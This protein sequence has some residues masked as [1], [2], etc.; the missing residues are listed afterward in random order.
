MAEADYSA[1]ERKDAVGVNA[2][3]PRWSNPLSLS[4]Y[5]IVTFH[6]VWLTY[7]ALSL[8]L[9]KAW[10]YLKN[11]PW[12]MAALYDYGC[13]AVFSFI[14]LW[15]RDGPPMFGI[16]GKYYA[17]IFPFAGNCVLLAYAAF[18]FQT[19]GNSV[20]ALLPKT[21]QSASPQKF[22]AT[23]I[24]GIIFAICTLVQLQA[25]IRA[26]REQSLLA[27]LKEIIAEPWAVLTVLDAYEGNLFGL[28]F[29]LVREG[30]TSVWTTLIWTLFFLTM[31]SF[32]I[33]LYALLVVREALVRD[34][35]FVEL[36][37]SAKSV[38][39]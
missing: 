37:L 1:V 36:L 12:S 30:T 11:S 38:T 25:Q 10:Q 6:V 5:A 3:R 34:V 35:S 26:L 27:G 31:H 9:P 18:L 14:I 8:S 7:A 39:S 4:L 20:S 24:F 19:H 15:F 22:V 23:A 21:G 28:L 13:N 2:K 29:V 16:K 32:A 33:T 17:L